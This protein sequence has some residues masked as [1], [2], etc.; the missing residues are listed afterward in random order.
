MWENLLEKTTLTI[1]YIYSHKC[2]QNKYNI[3]K[4]HEITRNIYDGKNKA[5]FIVRINNN[6]MTGTLNIDARTSVNYQWRHGILLLSYGLTPLGK[7][8]AIKAA[9]NHYCTDMSFSVCFL[10]CH[11]TD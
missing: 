4:H 9:W 6:N 3:N 5:K 7:L 1:S 10:N 2:K 8:R 11:T